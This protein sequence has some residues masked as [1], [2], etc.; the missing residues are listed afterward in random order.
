MFPYLSRYISVG[1]FII[2]CGSFLFFLPHIITEP[3]KPHGQDGTNTSVL[4]DGNVVSQADALIDADQSAEDVIIYLRRFKWFFLF[5]QFLHGVGAAPLITLGTTVLDESVDR[6]SAPLY[7]GI[8]QTFLVIGPAIGYIAG[9]SSLSVYGKNC[10]A[11]LTFFMRS[12]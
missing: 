2:G 4:C 10:D 7:I 11:K 5:G 3:Y 1:L 8:F 6:L 12:S 9:G